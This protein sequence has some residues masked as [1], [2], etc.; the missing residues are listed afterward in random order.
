MPLLRR[1]DDAA[2]VTSLGRTEGE[3]GGGMP[4]VGSRASRL[5]GAP[6]PPHLELVRERLLDR[7]DA[8]AALRV[9]RG[10]AGSGKTS[11]LAEWARRRGATGVWFTAT[12]A[13]SRLDLWRAVARRASR[14]GLEGFDAAFGPGELEPGEIPQRL[15]EAF[16]AV[17]GDVVVVVDEYQEV[18]GDEVHADVLALL[19]L[20]PTLCVAV[21]T[22]AVSPLEAP[23]VGL[24]LDRTV[25]TADQ[26]PFT[27]DETARVL[28]HSR[29]PLDPAEAHVRTGGQP[30]Y[31]R[32]AML[33]AEM[34]GS[35]GTPAHVQVAD[36]LLRAAVDKQLQGPARHRLET[37]LVRCAVPEILTADLAVALT[38]DPEAPDLLTVLE[39]RGLG[40]WERRPSGRVF[41][42]FPVVRTL[43]LET[44][45]REQPEESHRL[46]LAAARWYLANGYPVEALV[47][48][49]TAG[50]LDVASA[51]VSR[52]WAELLEPQTLARLGHLRRVPVHDL[53]RHPLLA[54]ALAIHHDSVPGQRGE[55]IELYRLVLASIKPRARA[56]S[57]TER[58]VL[59]VLESVAMRSTGSAQRAIDPARRARRSL[60]EL[61]L[62]ERRQLTRELPRLRAEI[63]LSLARAGASGEALSVLEDLGDSPTENPR[64]LYG[65]SLR[66]LVHAL[67][68]DMPEAERDLDVVDASPHEP[69]HAGR[70][71]DLY[72]LARA[73]VHLERFD[74]RGAQAHLDVMRPHLPTLES[75]PLFA[76]VQA[77]VDL[78]AFETAL[79]SERLRRYV[80][81]E[82]GARRISTR[83]I[84][85]L[86][87][88][89]GLL[90]LARGR[91]GAV[92]ALLKVAPAQSP[93]TPLL[94][95]HVALLTDGWQSARDVLV[96]HTP[97]P[98][99]SPRLRVAHWTLLAAT[100]THADD[101]TAACDALGK[102]AAVAEDRGLRFALALP[103]HADLLALAELA[104]RSR[105]QTAQRVL[106]DADRVP[107]LFVPVTDLP[108]PLTDREVVVLDALM[109]H[110]T[111]A[112]ISRSLMV[113]VNTV[114]S[115]LRSVYRKLGVRRREDALAKGIDLGLI[116]A[117]HVD[118]ASVLGDL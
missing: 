30:L 89:G 8:D 80:E 68:G 29:V 69:V 26:L 62:D 105:D 97:G 27:P 24:E 88:A 82:R 115:Q 23:A 32:V 87:Y 93:R 1:V 92:H 41:V 4:E 9:V 42:L 7:L 83:N 53:R 31:L 84:E 45:R 19:R 61:R 116:A 102:L 95:A 13:T 44:A 21:A 110:A 112:D 40:T 50:D 54:G 66:A 11:L 14:A 46:E 78:T 12:P 111:A 86:G 65:L 60:G 106:A 103:P 55:A 98:D 22:R 3:R 38:R 113:S 10:P 58:V 52:Y 74:A 57:P 73:L 39:E 108:Q 5:Y 48:A 109:R 37:L 90:N 18:E 33:A 76:T 117:D 35:H 25:I 36:E 49:V 72:R 107:E 104:A 70:D 2:D 94:R 75:R 77:Y 16:L 79:G 91:I 118:P 34:A 96:E 71:D 81:S 67:R 99:A 6:R 15:A 101:E 100:L 114:K 59:E 85:Q 64:T 47:H 20:C 43:V 28:R 56:A 63:A 51:A 17:A